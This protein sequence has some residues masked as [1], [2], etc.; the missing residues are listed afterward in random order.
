MRSHIAAHAEERGFDA[1]IRENVEHEVSCPEMRT[2]IECQRDRAIVPPPTQARCRI[3]QPADA[4]IQRHC[5]ATSHR[6]NV[7]LADP[8]HPNPTTHAA[9]RPQMTTEGRLTAT[10]PRARIFVEPADPHGL[11][12][13]SPPHPRTIQ[14]LLTFDQPATRRPARVRRAIVAG[15]CPVAQAMNARAHMLGLQN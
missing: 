14:D 15:A 1:K 2:V 13:S 8:G 10:S 4:V 3:R 5:H 7:L 11:T 12:D 6:S 9:G